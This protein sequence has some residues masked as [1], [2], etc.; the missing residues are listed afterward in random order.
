MG[1]ADLMEEWFSQGAADGFTMLSPY[2]PQPLE[3]FVDLVVPEATGRPG[4]QL[5]R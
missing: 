1:L 2:F 5:P 3:D 4:Y